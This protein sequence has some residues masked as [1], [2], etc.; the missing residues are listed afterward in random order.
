MVA[1]SPSAL[2]Q[3]LRPIHL[4]TALDI[5]PLAPGWY[6]LL[7]CGLLGLVS[8]LWWGWRIY[9]HG[10]AKRAALRMLRDVKT[11]AELAELLKRVALAYF[12][13]ERVAELHGK[14]WLLFLNA[15]SKNL[16]FLPEERALLL[17]PY[18][19]QMDCDLKPLLRLARLW[20]RQRGKPT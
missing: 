13:R 1:T 14:E 4:P 9:C 20:I 8:G 5:W 18:Q 11:A 12:P 7:G 17:C 19:A 3:Q 2:L 15:T 16:D 6:V 10:R